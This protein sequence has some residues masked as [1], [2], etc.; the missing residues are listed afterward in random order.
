MLNREQEGR[1]PKGKI[2]KDLV[3]CPQRVALVL[4][5]V[6]SQETEWGVVWQTL[7]IKGIV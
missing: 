6:R 3:G 2:A 4:N 7:Q 1:G 5:S